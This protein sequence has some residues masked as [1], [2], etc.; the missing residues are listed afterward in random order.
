MYLSPSL[1]S[2]GGPFGFRFS[3]L[4]R[5]LARKNVALS[6][7]LRLSSERTGVGGGTGYSLC[8]QGARLLCSLSSAL[9]LVGLPAGSQP[10]STPARALALQTRGVLVSEAPWQGANTLH[11]SRCCAGG[12]LCY[13]RIWF[14]FR[15]MLRH[16]GGGAACGGLEELGME[17]TG[18]GEHG[19]VHCDAGDE[20]R[21]ASG[22][23][24]ACGAMD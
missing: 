5:V 17:P 2:A 12:W 3:M 15:V 24:A 7:S 21:C 19:A 22:G 14:R 4:G 16:S 1:T 18:P 13:R 23:D 10:H 8:F 11:F 20:G 6:L 9:S